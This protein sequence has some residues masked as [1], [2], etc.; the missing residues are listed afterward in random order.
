MEKLESIKK[1][2]ERLPKGGDS[3]HSTAILYAIFDAIED[4]SKRSFKV[5][6]TVKEAS[7]YTGYSAAHIRRL[8]YNRKLPY[9]KPEEGGSGKLFLK[10]TD[11]DEYMSENRYPSERE[12]GERAATHLASVR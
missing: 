6:L 2:L 9:Y 11:L 3:K 8:V 1:E 7:Q 12:L 10:R 5:M 4:L